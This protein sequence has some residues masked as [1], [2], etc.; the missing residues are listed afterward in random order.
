MF[1]ELTPELFEGR[2]IQKMVK[3]SYAG[4]RYAGIL[5]NPHKT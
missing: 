2:K 4:L 3:I 5:R 1:N